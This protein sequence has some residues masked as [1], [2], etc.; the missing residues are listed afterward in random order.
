MIGVILVILYWSSL[1]SL[2]IVILSFKGAMMDKDLMEHL[3]RIN[4]KLSFYEWHL[5]YGGLDSDAKKV[6]Q[7]R[8]ENLKD[9][10]SSLNGFRLI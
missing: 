6:I 8:I 10:K 5:D 1:T 7:E 4:S 2:F 9:K 3:Q